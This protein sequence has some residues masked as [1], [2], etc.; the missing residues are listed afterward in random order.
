[1]RKQNHHDRRVRRTQKLIRKAFLKLIAEKEY[2]QITVTDIINEADYN[3]ATFYRHYYDKEHLVNEIVDHQIELFI[4][5][6]MK[7]YRYND[8]I[9]FSNLKPEHI[10]I[11]DHILEHQDFYSLWRELQTIPGF[12]QKYTDAIK[13]IYTNK[14]L[15][16]EALRKGIDQELYLQFYGDGIAGLIFNWIDSG[17]KQTPTYMVEQVI[18]ILKSAPSRT[19]LYP[20]VRIR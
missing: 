17:F 14:I 15:I 18:V 19:K 4:E 10:V 9:D 3:R 20:G 13:T 7:P 2:N 16:T 12:I 11:F 5:A 1:M 6:F 8:I